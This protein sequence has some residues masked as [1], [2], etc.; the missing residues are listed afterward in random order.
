MAI[1]IY[2]A[3]IPGIKNIKNTADKIQEKLMDNQIAKKR[4][5]NIPEMEAASLNFQNKKSAVEAAL[6][7]SE[8]VNF[9]KKLESLAE[10]TENKVIIKVIEED[11]QNPAV[12]PK[13]S[14]KKKNEEPSIKEKLEYQKYFLLELNVEGNYKGLVNFIHKAENTYNYVNIISLELKKTKEED[15]KNFTARSQISD[16]FTPQ[17]ITPLGQSPDNKDQKKQE[18]ISSILNVIVYTK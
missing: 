10:S 3:V 17:N 7:R 15:K 16:V 5:E 11:S 6:D 13:T 8:K 4:L 12:K 14:A 1:F 18:F 9:I 2:G